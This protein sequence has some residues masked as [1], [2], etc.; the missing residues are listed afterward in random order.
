MGL[1]N[2]VTKVISNDLKVNI[3]GL[4]IGVKDGIFDGKITLMVHDSTHLDMLIK[5]ME[6]VAGVVEVIRVD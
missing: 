3:V 1:V 4:T 5:R 6:D 2:D